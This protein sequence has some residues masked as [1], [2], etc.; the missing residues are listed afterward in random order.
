MNM[1]G[2]HMRKAAMGLA[3]AIVLGG[4]AVAVPD[5]LSYQGVLRDAGGAALNGSHDMVFRFFDAATAGSEILV[6]RHESSGTGAVLVTNGLFHVE[7]GSG[8]ITD[9]AAS[10]PGDPYTTLAAVFEDFND[11][12][13]E[14]EVGQGGSFETLSPR[15]HVVSAPYALRAASAEAVGGVAAGDIITTSATA[16]TKTGALQIDGNL[17]AGGNRILFGLGADLDAI[18]SRLT[19]T[20]GNANA[21]DL[22]L[23]AGN[24]S[25]DGGVEIHGTGPINLRSGSGL[26]NFMNDPTAAVTASLD[27]VGNFTTTGDLIA[28][29]NHLTFGS[30]ARLH[31]DSDVLH[32]GAGGLA[33]GYVRITR[34]SSMVLASSI[35]TFLF[36]GTTPVATLSP[37]ELSLAGDLR[38]RGNDLLFDSGA[39]LFSVS[40]SNFTIRAGTG[41]TGITLRTASNTGSV[42]LFDGANLDLRAGNGTVR[43]WPAG[44]STFTASVDSAGTIT[45]GGNLV[46]NGNALLFGNG[47]RLAS[48]LEGLFVLGGTDPTDSIHLLANSAGAGQISIYG[49]GPLELHPGNGELRVLIPDPPFVSAQLD[50]NGNFGVLGN[51]SAKRLVALANEI[52]LGGTFAPARISR[53]LTF[54]DLILRRDEFQNNSDARFSVFTNGSIEQ[55]RIND[56][57]EAAALFDGAVTANGLDYAEAF[58]ISDP[59]LQPGEVVVFDTTN[60]GSIS[61]AAEAYSTLIAGVISEKPGFVTGNSFDAEEASDP[62]LAQEMKAAHEAGDYETAREISSVLEQKKN[63]RQRPV[64]LAGRLPVKVDASY[65]PIKPGDHLTSSK[66]PGHAMAMTEPGPSL[67]VALEG[68]DGPGTGVIMAFVQRGH[69]TPPALLAQTVATQ[70]SLSTSLAAR[71]PDPVSGVQMIPSNLQVVLDAQGGEEAA[72]FSIFRDGSAAEPRAEMFRVDEKGNV[73]AQGAFRPRAMDL[74]EMFALSE[75]VEPGD[76]LVADRRNPGLYARSSLMG[77]PAVVGVVA[78]DPGVILGADMSR[79]LA[80][81]ADLTQALAQARAASDKAA[82]RGVWAEMEKRFHATHAAVAL[83]GTL[84][85]KVDADYGPIEP[86]DLLIA[87]PTPG[88]AMRAPSPAPEGAVIGKALESLDAGA[89]VIRMIVALR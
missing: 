72:R 17:T 49:G 63:E 4:S 26:V 71:T 88:H 7:M 19:I 75:P 65:G 13:M 28:Q 32:L 43:F 80:A 68:W 59:T 11:V 89:G 84:K 34:G 39:H 54:E 16:Q 66:T 82:E 67:G 33:D 61:R 6:D 18:A 3:V 44:A 47:A 46:T 24:G 74:A 5:R 27:A 52:L 31:F 23:R 14:I 10:L 83:S 38:V 50:P 85:V 87:S 42:D 35:G 73:W 62:A 77:D 36:G 86:G 45:A 70:Q 9:G 64:A 69:Y 79:L 78:S 53:S 76:V 21:D 30:G 1:K 51:I 60:P 22:F 37:A 8:A 29:G 58:L 57:D 41:D 55:M 15:T 25:F 20:G 40:G 81:E 2:E 48:F 12:W 56:S